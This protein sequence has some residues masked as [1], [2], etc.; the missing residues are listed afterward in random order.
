VSVTGE[1][2]VGFVGLEV[3]GGGVEE[4]QIHLMIEQGRDLPEHL[5]LQVTGNVE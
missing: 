2:G 1:R 5:F 3:G 4:Q